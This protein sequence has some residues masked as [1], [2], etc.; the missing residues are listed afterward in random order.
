MHRLEYLES[1]Y[2]DLVEAEDYLYE[3]SVSA[4]DKL[5]DAINVQLKILLD[6]PYM[7]PIYQHDKRFRFIVLPYQYLCFYRVDEDTNI[8]TVHRILRSMQDII[9][10]L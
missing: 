10:I 4:V 2:T 3:Y 5:T 7:Y 1:F 9:S 8:I 6:K